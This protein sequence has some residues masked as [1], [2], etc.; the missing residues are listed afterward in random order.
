[1][2]TNL[3]F[4]WFPFQ[5]LRL[6][7]DCQRAGDNS[8]LQNKVTV[9]YSGDVTTLTLNLYNFNQEVGRSTL[10]CLQAVSNHFALG[11][12]L[13]LEFAEKQSL[14]ADVALAARYLNR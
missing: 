4:I 1:M 6:A 10:S 12:E 5:C 7:A 2:A 11:G 13:L 9:E 14:M 8:P 3:G